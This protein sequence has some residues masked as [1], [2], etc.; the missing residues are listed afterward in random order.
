MS[1]SSCPSPRQPV[2]V[3]S[4]SPRSTGRRLSAFPRIDCVSPTPG[5]TTPAASP[6]NQRERSRSARGWKRCS[7]EKTHSPA[8]A[9]TC[10]FRSGSGNLVVLARICDQRR[11]RPIPRG[12]RMQGCRL[13]AGHRARWQLL[14]A[15]NRGKGVEQQLS[16]NVPISARAAARLDRTFW[17]SP[18]IKYLVKSELRRSNPGARAFAAGGDWYSTHQLIRFTGGGAS[19]T[20]G[21]MTTTR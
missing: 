13:G 9:G 21:G 7:M 18:E 8:G 11:Q 6:S 4:L 1:G 17:Y 12:S 20:P 3:P 15:P 5:S 10:P 19:R 2:P 16:L 14:G